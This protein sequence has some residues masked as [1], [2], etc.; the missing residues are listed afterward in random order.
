MN[1]D[2]NKYIS[3]NKHKTEITVPYLRQA[4]EIFVEVIS[5]RVQLQMAYSGRIMPKSVKAHNLILD[6]GLTRWG[7]W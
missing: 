2:T 4:S 5:K 3:I 1:M 7:P 6:P